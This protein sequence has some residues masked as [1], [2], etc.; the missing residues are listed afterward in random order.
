MPEIISEIWYNLH[1]LFASFWR[2]G[3]IIKNDNCKYIATNSGMNELCAL[4]RMKGEEWRKSWHLFWLQQIAKH[5]LKVHANADSLAKGT[6]VQDQE[7]WLKRYI[8]S[9]LLSAMYQNL[10]SCSHI[11]LLFLDV[12]KISFFLNRV[13]KCVHIKLAR[14]VLLAT[15]CWGHYCLHYWIRCLEMGHIMSACFRYVEWSRS[16]C[17]PRLTDSA[18]QLLQNNY[19]KIR[20][21]WMPFML[22]WPTL[23]CSEIGCKLIP[24]FKP[25]CVV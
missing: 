1:T 15:V 20:Q 2:Q 12:V 24:I 13:S 9:L 23:K 8:K 19:V 10:H 25:V 17:S 7:N 3:E 22:L 21:V 18:A 14:E 16:H 11:F 5:I 6:E 4:K